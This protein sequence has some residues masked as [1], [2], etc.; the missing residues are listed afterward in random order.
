MRQFSETELKVLVL[1]HPLI[2]PVVQRYQYCLELYPEVLM[3]HDQVVKRLGF[4]GDTSDNPDLLWAK[5][6]VQLVEEELEI[7]ETAIA[8]AIRSG[9]LD[10]EFHSEQ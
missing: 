2:K 8:D 4:K 1:R 9:R 3:E 6:N 10:L 7:A 5:A